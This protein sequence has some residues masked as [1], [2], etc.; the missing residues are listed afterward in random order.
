MLRL[1]Y[2]LLLIFQSQLQA[3]TSK[4]LE[5]INFYPNAK[6][7]LRTDYSHQ[8]LRIDTPQKQINTKEVQNFSNIFSLTYA[9]KFKY[10]FLGVKNFYESASESAVKYGIPENNQYQS[11]GIKEPELFIL[12]RLRKQKKDKANIDLYVSYVE[13]FGSREIGES[14]ANRLNGGNIFTINASHGLLDE[15]WEFRNSFQYVHFYKG[16]EHNNFTEKKYDLGG[17]GLLT[18]LFM[19]QYAVGSLSYLN[20]AIG[21]DYRS[22]QKISDRDSDKRELQAGTGTV[23]YLGYKRLLGTWTLAEFMY[24]IRRNSYFVKNTENYDGLQ[25]QH[26]F[27][28]SLIQAF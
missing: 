14:S 23:L 24:G 19:G 17:Y 11:Q 28:L 25:T 26:T 21:I 2:L 12:T 15:E 8:I 10:L 7:Y 16:E 5:R 9:Y 18:Y 4:E 27:L 13:S 1:F 20:T 3:Q 6:A 22:V